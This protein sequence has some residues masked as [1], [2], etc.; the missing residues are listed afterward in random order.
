MGVEEVYGFLGWVADELDLWAQELALARYLGSVSS[1]HSR[2]TRLSMP[3][4]S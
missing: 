1:G 4:R 3:R 2:L